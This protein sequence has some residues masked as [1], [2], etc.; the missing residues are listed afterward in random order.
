MAGSAARRLPWRRA[1]EEIAVRLDVGKFPPFRDPRPPG[2]RRKRFSPVKRQISEVNLNAF[3]R[4]PEL[5]IRHNMDIVNI[6][7]AQSCIFYEVES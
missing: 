6:I 2:R 1:W 5:T 7:K 4:Y 3:I